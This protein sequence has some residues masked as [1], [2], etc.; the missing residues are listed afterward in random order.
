MIKLFIG[1]LRVYLNDGIA[2]KEEISIAWSKAADEYKSSYEL[3]SSEQ[4]KIKD[5]T[6]KSLKN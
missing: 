4:A 2:T 1:E 6:K 3:F 5:Q